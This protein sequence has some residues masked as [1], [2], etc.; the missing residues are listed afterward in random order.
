MSKSLNR[1]V[2]FIFL[3]GILFQSSAQNKEIDYSSFLAQHDLSWESAPKNRHESAFLGNGML[4]ATIWS[5]ED[6]ALLFK[7]GRNDVYS[8][9]EQV[10][11][12]MLIGRLVLNLKEKVSKIKMRQV[13]NDAEVKGTISSTT[14][15][16][17]WR[18]IIPHD[19]MVGLVEFTTTNLK[20]LNIDFVPLPFANPASLRVAIT[21]ELEKRK[22]KSK[23]MTDFADPYYKEI[24]E[25]L[26]SDKKL[27]CHP[28]AEKGVT[29]GVS[30]YIQEYNT[31]GG[32]SVAWKLQ[33]TKQNKVLL[34]Y[35]VD[36]EYKHKPSPKELISRLN[37][38]IDRGYESARKTHISWWKNFY[39][40]SFVS[41]PNKVIEKYF[42]LQVY[43][44]GSATRSDG[45]ILDE[46]GPWPGASAWVRVWTNLNIQLAYHVP[47]TINHTELCKPFIKFLN[48]NQN[49]FA[50]AVPQK[51]RANGALA[52]GRMTDIWGKGGFN[53]EF[54]NFTWA[55]HDYWLY[56]RY[57]ADDQLMK[58]GLYPLLKGAINFNINALT[59]GTDGKYHL[60][61]DVSPEYGLKTPDTNYN[62]SLLI[63]GLKTLQNINQ[64]F[65]I[66]D[67]QA[68]R[69]QEVLDKLA[70]LA[71]NKTG[72]MIGSETTFSKGHR[73][74]SH[75]LSFYPLHI[76][77]PDKTED[78]NLFYK[79]YKNWT[80]YFP[81]G[82]NFFSIGGEAAM[83]A[84]LRKGA[85]AEAVLERGIKTKIS[86]NSFFQGAGP[87]IESGLCAVSP[88]T[89]M[90]LQSWSFDPNK[91]HIRVFPAIPDTWNDARFDNL[92]AEGAFL[93]SAEKSK[94]E[95]IYLKIISLAGNTCTL[96]N[97]FDGEFKVLGK[98]NIKK[99]RK[100]DIQ[101]RSIITIKLKKGEQITLIKE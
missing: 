85:E 37:K 23:R 50:K 63:W 93:V 45:V 95:L 82:E 2:I 84:W 88:I 67:K 1:L 96:E 5:K 62:T 71:I 44:L 17:Q 72:L 75:L 54:G 10:G 25:D 39:Q 73:H 68:A 79:S 19:D 97:P 11:S 3:V 40:K 56:C 69:W 30:W 61:D 74:Y 8:E 4:G 55:L 65:N 27:F 70:P 78:K 42:W 86:K 59:L 49:K 90:L 99:S 15:D 81:K 87:A 46:L 89:E 16:I 36:R 48:E 33:K 77:N 53:K 57:I 31:G 91:Y 94:G 28:T 26:L 66:K 92:R 101:G 18:T 34:C 13:L 14:K 7:L 32:F 38:A 12:R 58:E 80:S 41:I 9:G 24:I 20:N 83:A 29:D 64:K 21:S 60:P 98:S 6:E 43:K 76:L 52:I 22:M 47:L 51:W 100:K 35:T